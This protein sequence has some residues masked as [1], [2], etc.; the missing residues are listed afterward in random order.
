MPSQPTSSPLSARLANSAFGKAVGLRWAALLA[1]PFPRLVAHFASVILQSGQD[2]G[3][4]ELNL[5]I[6]GILALLAAP[7]AFASLMLFPKYSSFLR[8][9]SGRRRFDV[10]WASLPDKYFFIVF[11]MAVTG[12]V[13]AVKWDRIFPGRQDYANLA[14]LPLRSRTIFFANL[15]AIV[16]LASVFAIDV[17]AASTL[18]MPGVVLSERG[19]FPGFV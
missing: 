5:G 3:A 16:L 18:M 9:L 13:V 1:R 14:Q 10:Y 7:G 17:N 2:S 11:S 12:V 4:S 6:G 15:T 8:W 19:T